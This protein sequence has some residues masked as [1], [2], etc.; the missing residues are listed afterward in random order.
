[1]LYEPSLKITVLESVLEQKFVVFT[2]RPSYVYQW[3]HSHHLTYYVYD[4]QRYWC[5][6]RMERDYKF[7]KCHN[8]FLI[9]LL[10]S[11][12]PLPFSPF[13]FSLFIFNFFCRRFPI[14]TKSQCEE[15]TCSHKKNRRNNRENSRNVFHALYII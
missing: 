12:F 15:S 6:L 14:L 9:I 2:H 3:C 11:T 5:C 10:P 7:D 1:M 8:F 4:D 13:H